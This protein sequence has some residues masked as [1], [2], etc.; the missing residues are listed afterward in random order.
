MF[1]PSRVS[2]AC[3]AQAY[4]QVVPITRRTALGVH[5]PG[6]RGRAQQTQQAAGRHAPVGLQKITQT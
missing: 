1:E 4:E 6:Q 2:P 3:V 5:H